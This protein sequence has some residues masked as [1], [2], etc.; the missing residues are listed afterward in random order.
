MTA[1]KWRLVEG[2]VFK[3]SRTFD[4]CIDALDYARI[5][6]RTHYTVLLKTGGKEWAIYWRPRVEVQCESKHYSVE[7]SSSGSPSQLNE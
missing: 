5:L 2:C 7:D 1:K 3:L 6:N 4:N